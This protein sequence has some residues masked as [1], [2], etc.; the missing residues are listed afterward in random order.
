MLRIRRCLDPLGHDPQGEPE[1][2]HHAQD[3]L[4]GGG[5][6]T[7]SEG[8]VLPEVFERDRERRAEDRWRWE[9]P[10]EPGTYLLGVRETV[11]GTSAR[12]RIFVMRPYAGEETF[13]GYQIGTYPLGTAPP[14]FIRVDG[15]ML[16][17][18]VSPHFR[19]APFL[20]KQAGD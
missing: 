10:S 1:V 20:A 15:G 19:L 14:G 7:A 5:Q 12:L 6:R 17:L 9:A 4:Q 2:D 11:S 8:R 3:V 13:D 16:D 18:P